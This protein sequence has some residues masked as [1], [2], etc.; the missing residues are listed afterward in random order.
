LRFCFKDDLNGKKTWGHRG[1]RDYHHNETQYNNTQ[2]NANQHN[3]TQHSVALE[4]L[5]VVYSFNSNKKYLGYYYKRIILSFISIPIN[6]TF[7]NF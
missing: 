7:Y 1:R 5:G 2:H 6:A 3:Y 4:C